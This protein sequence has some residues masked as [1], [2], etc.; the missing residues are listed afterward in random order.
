VEKLV[1]CLWRRPDADLEAIR[2]DLLGR[3]SSE[4]LGAGV[5]GLRLEIEEPAGELFRTG[6]LPDGSLLCA[7]VSVWLDSYDDRGP[8]EAAIDAVPGA[9]AHG[10]LVCESVAKGYGARRTWPDGERS[11]GMSLLTVLDKAP[12]VDD[13]GF[14]RIWHG[15][16]T[17]LTFEIHPFW[18]YVRNQVARAITSGAPAARGIVY[19]AVAHDEH[20]LDLPTFFGCP[21]EPNRLR[22]Q[23]EV[24]EDHIATFADPST[25][26]CVVTREWIVRTFST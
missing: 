18:L 1:Y 13:A 9:T 7:S 25:L 23:L 2:T 3:V 26:Q 10:W 17:P 15:E 16:H 20:L 19:E 6:S 11:P 14:Y 12:H 21:G 8:V 22:A 24:V 4:V 5:A